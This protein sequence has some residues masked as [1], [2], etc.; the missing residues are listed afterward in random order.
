MKGDRAVQ[1]LPGQGAA[2]TE[3]DARAQGHV[4]EDPGARTE[5][6]HHLGR[7]SSLG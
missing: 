1:A 5:P 4:L 2:P 7:G 6:P 3:R